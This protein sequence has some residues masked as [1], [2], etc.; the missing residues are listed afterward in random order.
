MESTMLKF[1]TFITEMVLREQ[2]SSDLIYQ[3]MLDVLDDA[4]IDFDKDK[5]CFHI[6]RITKNSAVDLF[7]TIRPSDAPSVRLG[8][9][10]G[11]MH[12]VVD[13]EDRLPVRTEI[14]AFLAKDR[15][16]A[17][18]IKACIDNYMSQHYSGDSDGSKTRYEDEQLVNGKKYFEAMYEKVVAELHDRIEEYN[19]ACDDLNQQMDTEDTGVRETG[20][21]A[22]RHL[23]KEYFGD[24]LEEFKKIAMG[25]LNNGVDGKNSAMQR[26]LTKE[27]KEKLENRLDSFYDQKVKPIIKA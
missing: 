3:K 5:I 23:A 1:K 19:E 17:S 12:I 25:I 11:V 26:Q 10:D 24:N 27:N 14:D 2:A 4:H 16:R 6:G 18:A 8:K 20:K 9:K 13:V 22:H 15:K 7:M 21:V